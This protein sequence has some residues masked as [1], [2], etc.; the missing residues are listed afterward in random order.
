M[1]SHDKLIPAQPPLSSTPAP[2]ARAAPGEDTGATIAWRTGG[3]VTVAFV[4]ACFALYFGREFFV[5]IVFA[6]L[7]NALCRPLVRGLHNY[8]RI[9]EPIAAG[10]IVLGL[11]G[12]M[13]TA[14]WLLAGPIHR[15]FTSAP[16]WFEQAQSKLDKF[17]RPMQQATEVANKLEQAAQGPTTGPAAEEKGAPPPATPQGSGLLSRAFGGT[18]SIISG[19]VGV[20]LL[21]YL[22]LASGDLFY[23]KLLRVIPRWR[24]KENA[25]EGVNEVQDV[26]MR[27]LLVTLMINTGQGVI[28]ALVLW[29][30]GMPSPWIWG[31]LT[32]VLEFIPYLGAMVMVALLAITAFATFASLGHAMLAPGSYLLI[33]TIQNN[34]VSPY[35]YGNRLKLNP[36]AVL[37]GVLLWWFLWGVPGA[38]LAVPLIATIKI[39]A[40]RTDS[41][42]AVGEFLGE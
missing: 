6:V 23:R 30:L 34:V 41:M 37:L 28:V 13:V 39:I 22:L 10:I 9:P 24:D 14:G 26:I 3:I 5:P 31:L 35:A 20:L 1:Q 36:V 18:A 4:A 33:T 42:K 11:I 12:V 17:R 15:W 2:A 16:Q 21:A 8:F 7:L 38:F 19:I 40:D 29:W 32:I 25:A 27:Y